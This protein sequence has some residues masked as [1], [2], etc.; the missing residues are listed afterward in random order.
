M[1]NWN[2]FGITILLLDSKMIME[3]K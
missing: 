2:V 1:I 3:L